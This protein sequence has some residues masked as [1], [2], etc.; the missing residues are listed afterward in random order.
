MPNYNKMFKL[1]VKAI[2]LIE[3]S[4]HSQI[5]QLTHQDTSNTAIDNHK[6][7]AALIQVGCKS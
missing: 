3:F 7:I 5:R 1:S 2:N 4:S 6:K